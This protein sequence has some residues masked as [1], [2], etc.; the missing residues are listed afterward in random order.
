[1]SKRKRCFNVKSSAD[2]FCIKTKILQDF[3]ICISVPLR[4]QEKCLT[5]IS[6]FLH[7]ICFFPITSEAIT[8]IVNATKS[9]MH[10]INFL[11]RK[12]NN[13][14][15]MIK[16]DE[17]CKWTCQFHSYFWCPSDIYRLLKITVVLLEF[18]ADMKSKVTLV[19][20][21]LM[22][23]ALPKKWSFPLRIPSVN[24][25]KSGVP[26]GFGHIYWRNL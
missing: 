15:K 22:V 3:Q 14:L 13:Y 21:R 7:F 11:T 19:R 25:T 4:W 8:A 26:C 17:F 20:D 9:I 6:I 10:S 16:S 23:S 1:M 2:D 12:A 18:F 5:T 24:V